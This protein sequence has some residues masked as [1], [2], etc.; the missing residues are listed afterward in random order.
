M[1]LCS[2]QSAP[3]VLSFL[4]QSLPVPGLWNLLNLQV[5]VW[6]RRCAAGNE[7]T[8]RK[9][10][11]LRP[12]CQWLSSGVSTTWRRTS[13]GKP[14]QLR[15]VKLWSS[16]VAQAALAAVARERTWQQLGRSKSPRPPAAQLDIQES[17]Q[18]RWSLLAAPVACTCT[19][20]HQAGLK[21]E[22]RQKVERVYE[23]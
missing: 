6:S 16:A 10:K 9:H 18:A 5:C 3:C 8:Q 12:G 14:L 20:R 13:C 22:M 17:K 11:A 1:F 2:V 7:R 21:A 23:P 19:E 15:K 4:A